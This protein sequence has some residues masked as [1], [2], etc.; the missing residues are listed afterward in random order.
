MGFITHVAINVKNMEK[1]LKFYKEV[2]G[3]EKIFEISNPETGKPWIVYVQVDRGQFLELF[4]T[5]SKAQIT[6]EPDVGMNHICF[7][8]DNVPEVADKIEAAGYELF[9]RPCVGCDHNMQ[10]WVKDPNGVRIEI[11]QIS[12]QSP[13]FHYM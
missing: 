1:S 13:H 5:D 9:I 10:A 11:M 6:D 3:F 12:D 2:F 8:V 7:C 4:Y